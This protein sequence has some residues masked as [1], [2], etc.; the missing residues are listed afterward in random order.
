MSRRA[1]LSFGGMP[2][3]FWV[4]LFVL[5]VNDHLLKGSGLLPS[6]VTGKL[7]DFAGLIVAPVLLCAV[8]SVRTDRGRG[9]AIGW[10]ALAFAA[11]KLS[12]ACA[13]QAA[14]LLTTLGVPSR[15]WCDPTDLIAFAILPW[16][17]LLARRVQPTPARLSRRITV[18][19]ASLACVATSSDSPSHTVVHGPFL[20][21]W[22]RSPIVAHV[23]R[24]WTSCAQPL[25]GGETFT[26]QGTP[27]MLVPAQ[28]SAIGWDLG[29][30]D[31]GVGSDCGLADIQVAGKRIRVAWGPLVGEGLSSE[32]DNDDLV[33]E[34]GIIVYGSAESPSF[35]LGAMLQQD[36]VEP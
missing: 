31:A 21:N 3:A 19:V 4:A 12:P 24:S 14:A 16:A 22:T 29:L 32:A 33:F 18:A 25:A 27:M 30:V 36:G 9:L 15:I 13:Q 5:V 8:L 11:I 6:L 23:S 2:S 1:S 34:R 28:V 7:S 35:E 20:I 10:V 26:P 17:A